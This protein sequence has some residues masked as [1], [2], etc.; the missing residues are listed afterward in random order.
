MREVESPPKSIQIGL[1]RQSSIMSSSSINSPSKLFGKRNEIDRAIAKVNFELD[2]QFSSVDRSIDLESM[3]K[4]NFNLISYEISPKKDKIKY[5]PQ[6]MSSQL[7]R[8]ENKAEIK[9]AEMEIDQREKQR[10]H[11][12]TRK[13]ASIDSE[14]YRKVYE[15]FLENQDLEEMMERDSD[16]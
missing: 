14:P 1:R 12:H 5:D 9:R 13:K 6:M 3:S 8:L 11:L 4:V 15:K 2:S 10:R 16:D 7:Q